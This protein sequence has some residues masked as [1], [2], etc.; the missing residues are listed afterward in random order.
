MNDKPYLFKTIK[1]K[2]RLYNPN[3]GDER[4]CKCK[5]PY[6]RHFDTYEENILACGCKYC[7]CMIFT[8]RKQNEKSM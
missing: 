1:I 3:Y 2:K 8:E 5:H 4:I 7:E 6:I